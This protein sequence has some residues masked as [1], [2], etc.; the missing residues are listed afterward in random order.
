MAKQCRSVCGCTSFWRPARWAAC[1]S[2]PDHL[3]RDGLITR[4]PAV[5]SETAIAWLSSQAAPVL[6]E[7]FQQLWAEHHIAVFAAFT[8]L[9]V[10]DHA[11]TV[12]VADFQCVEFGTPHS[13][14]IERHQHSAM[15]G[16]EQHR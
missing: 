5:A 9:D 4:V 12:D 16:F 13:G 7:S 11:L 14:G 6:P 10:D 2:V 3:G 8:A 1:C 15:Q